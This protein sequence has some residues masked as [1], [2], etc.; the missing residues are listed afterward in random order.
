M[1]FEDPSV[2]THYAKQVSELSFEQWQ[3]FIKNPGTP[4]RDKAAVIRG[5]SD[6]S[7]SDLK[8]RLQRIAIRTIKKYDTYGDGTWSDVRHD[9]HVIYSLLSEKGPTSMALDIKYAKDAIYNVIDSNRDLQSVHKMMLKTDA[10][11]WLKSYT[12][13]LPHSNVVIRELA[14]QVIIL[15]KPV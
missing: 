9:R 4:V 13:A 8:K 10:G 14:K 15:E 11:K 12:D 2:I 7:V 5:L 3:W 6:L 1:R